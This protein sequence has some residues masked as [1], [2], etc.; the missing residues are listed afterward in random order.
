M[1]SY[2]IYFLSIILLLLTISIFAQK[3]QKQEIVAKRT[4]ASKTF[5]N[6]DGSYTLEIS[7]DYQHYKDEQG[8]FKEIQ[9]EFVSSNK[10]GYSHQITKGFYSVFLKDKSKQKNGQKFV[11]REGHEL[12]MN[13]DAMCY[14]NTSS[15]EYKKISD[16]N[17]TKLSINKNKAFYKNILKGIDLE[18]I[19]L[20]DRLKENIYLSQ[21]AR[22]NLPDP[23]KY[24]FK[25][26]DTYLMFRSEIDKS[27]YLSI[28]HSNA[29][30]S[31][32][33]YETINRLAFKDTDGKE[34]FYFANDLASFKPKNGELEFEDEIP[35]LK[36]IYWEENQQYVLYGVPLKWLNE[37]VDGEV[38]IDPTIDLNTP[39]TCQDARVYKWDGDING[40]TNLNLGSA[41][42]NLVQAGTK[43]GIPK[44]DRS[45]IKFDFSAIPANAKISSA[46]LILI[47]DGSPH[48]GGVYSRYSIS[49]TYLRRVTEPWNEYSITW[50]NQPETTEDNKISIAAPSNGY[51]PL[52][53]YVTNLVKD[54]LSSDEGNNGFQ[55]KLQ[56]EQ[57]YRSVRY[58][59]TQYGYSSRWPKLTITYTEMQ[60]AY[61]LKD[62]LGNIR[63]TLDGSGDVI[64]TDDYY[65]FGMQMPGRSYNIAINSDIYKFSGKELDE[66]NGLDWYYFGARYY[67]PKIGRW[68]VPDVLGQDHSIYI[69]CGNNPISRKDPTGLYWIKEVKADATWKNNWKPKPGYVVRFDTKLSLT[70]DYI[71]SF[72]DF[73]KIGEMKR[74]RGYHVSGKEEFSAFAWWVVGKNVPNKVGKALDLASGVENFDIFDWEDDPELVSKF[75]EKWGNAVFVSKYAAKLA[76]KGIENDLRKIRKKRYVPMIQQIDITYGIKDNLYRQYGPAK[77]A[78]YNSLADD[79]HAEHPNKAIIVDGIRYY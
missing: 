67:D 1:K 12:N 36:K 22:E 39:Q 9:K 40:T 15:G 77:G 72:F 18:Y 69:Y 61:Y 34:L 20:S 35:V 7:L 68:F 46:Q 43:N 79:L 78:G 31:K 50:A 58:A 17:E 5:D 33:G 64:T 74:Q 59:S 76:V 21:K 26:E 73:S 54:I 14:Y 37:L 30:I 57:Y 71:Q 13:P 42:I 55:L 62:H 48:S 24:D 11:T 65:P 2:K 47:N 23:K 44:Y 63:V 49:S 27:K 41:T 28:F 10:K 6:G 56:T 60:E 8:N 25:V 53:E 19:Y 70:A 3:K 4:H 51:S 38:I 32:S 45:Y 66:E 75:K 16:I 52:N 29:Q